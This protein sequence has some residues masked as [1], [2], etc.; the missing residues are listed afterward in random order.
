MVL[1]RNLDYYGLCQEAVVEFKLRT[2]DYS[3]NEGS[4]GMYHSAESIAGKLDLK[5]WLHLV[6]DL[7]EG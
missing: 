2:H 1:G 3:S 7:V 4:T 5:N 6:L